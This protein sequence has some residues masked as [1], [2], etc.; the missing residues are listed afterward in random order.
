[1]SPNE[2]LA[3]LTV[4]SFFTLLMVGVPVAVGL[5]VSGF[6]FG[7]IGF[8]AELFNLLPLRIFGV[9]TNYTLMA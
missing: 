2:I 4:V 8:G 1:M 5:A 3:I 6:V 9:V 7:Y